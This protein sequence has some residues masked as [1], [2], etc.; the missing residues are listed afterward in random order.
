MVAI[1]V[2][3]ELRDTGYGRQYRDE[4]IEPA[5]DAAIWWPDYVPYVAG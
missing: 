3:R 1:A 2:V 5:V 4:E